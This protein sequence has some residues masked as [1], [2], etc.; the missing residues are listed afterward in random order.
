MDTEAGPREHG[1]EQS[2]SIKGGEFLD[3]PSDYQLLKKLC[4]MGLMST[5]CVTFRVNVSISH[6]KGLKHFAPV[7]L[8][9]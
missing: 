6:G 3:Y 8:E 4:S 1:S 2:G 7:L 5:F 9:P